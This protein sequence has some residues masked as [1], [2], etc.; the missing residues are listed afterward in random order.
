MF[1]ILFCHII[2]ELSVW[3]FF[4]SCKYNSVIPFFFNMYFKMNLTEAKINREDHIVRQTLLLTSGR[5]SASEMLNS[6]IQG[7]NKFSVWICWKTEK[8]NIQI[9]FVH[10]CRQ[11]QTGCKYQY[12]FKPLY[13]CTFVDIWKKV[14]NISICADQING[15]LQKQ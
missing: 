9:S 8:K 2:V 7:L 13:I 10:I 3:L 5:Y 15:K 1:N 4:I 6:K 14:S 11:M 12:H